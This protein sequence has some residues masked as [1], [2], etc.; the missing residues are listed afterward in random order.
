M[1]KHPLQSGFSL[2]EIAIVLVIVG[3]LLG[4]IITPMAS[5]HQQ[6]KIKEAETQ[7][8]DI[9]RALLGFAILNDRLPC[10]AT[11]ASNG[12]AAPNGATTNC[13]QEHGFIPG[14]TL[15]FD[16]LQNANSITTDPGNPIRYSLT[17][18][19]SGAFSDQI[20]VNQSSG[21]YTVCQA[22]SC[23]ADEVITDNA[24]A[25]ICS[26]G[27]NGA[28]PINSQNQRENTD[29]DIRFVRAEFSEAAGSE[30]DDICRWI[31]PNVLALE[32]SRVGKL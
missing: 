11:T 25:I 32:L 28:Q 23:A 10:P 18:F 6:K 5:Q 15:G 3:V 26:L 22:S 24:T 14:N 31:S 12:L 20:T 17:N 27:K 1:T 16:A 29:A 30:F 19:D 8:E 2:I 4:G 21:D 13:T 7:L 9:Y